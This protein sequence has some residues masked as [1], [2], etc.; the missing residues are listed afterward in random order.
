[1]NNEPKLQRMTR[2][3]IRAFY[4]AKRPLTLNEIRRLLLAF[5]QPTD[6][7]RGATNPNAECGLLMNEASDL[8]RRLLDLAALVEAQQA[9]MAAW[10]EDFG[11]LAAMIDR[12][13]KIAAHDCHAHPL[14][15]EQAKR[16]ALPLWST[17]AHTFGITPDEARELARWHGYDPDTGAKVTGAKE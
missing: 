13:V 11:A 3:E 6:D 12:A 4:D 9:T 5:D 7:N 14:H 1:M 16:R 8:A 17:L 2:A 10:Q 15:T